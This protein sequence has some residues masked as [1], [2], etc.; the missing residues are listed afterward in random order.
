MARSPLQN[1]WQLR[2]RTRIERHI[3]LEYSEIVL[4]ERRLTWF[5]VADPD[6]LLKAALERGDARSDE[7]DPFWAATWRAARGLDEFLTRFDLTDRRILEIG[8]GSGQAGVAAAMQGAYVTLTDAVGL[9]L[10]VARLNAWPVRE[11]TRFRRLR[12]DCDQLSEPQFPIMI[13]SD[14]VYDPKHFP[15]INACARKHLEPQ[16]RVYLSEP[17]RQSG[18]HFAR[19]I[20]QAG[21]HMLEHDILLEA[22][23]LPIR[24]FECWLS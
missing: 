11:R 15:L 17:H 9:A 3:Q 5:K 8:C 4:A 14:L 22:D 16:G 10:L 1:H 18:D 2:L 12:W 7:V 19:W 13:G 20:V 21:W 6:R 23:R 24:V